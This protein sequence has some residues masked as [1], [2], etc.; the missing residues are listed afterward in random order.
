MKKWVILLLG[1]AIVTTTNAQKS[2]YNAQDYAQK[3][4]W[5][6][7][8]ADTSVNFF[9]AEKAFNTYFQHHEKPNGEEESIGEQP[10]KHYSK[11]ERREMQEKDHLRMDV[12]RYQR[13]HDKMLPFVRPDGRILT[14]NQ[15]LEIWKSQH[16]NK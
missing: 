13:W 7:M 4:I 3:P 9:E 8:V 2:K 6:S 10:K 5:L 15:R 12:K 1:F 16:T 14:P 11:K